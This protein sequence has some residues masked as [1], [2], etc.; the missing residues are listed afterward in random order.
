V[1]MVGRCTYQRQGDGD[2]GGAFARLGT[3]DDH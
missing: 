3:T 1:S 2:L